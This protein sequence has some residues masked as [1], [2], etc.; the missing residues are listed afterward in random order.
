MDLFILRVKVRLIDRIWVWGCSEELLKNVI[1]YTGVQHV[2]HVHMDI[3][4][5]ANTPESP[6]PRRKP[7][8]FCAYFDIS[9]LAYP[10]GQFYGTNTIK[11]KHLKQDPRF[12][13]REKPFF[14]VSAGHCPSSETQ[15][16]SRPFLKTFAAVFPDLINCPWVSKHGHCHWIQIKGVPV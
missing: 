8:Q 14:Y 10:S 11:L 6:Q 5:K 3:F 7:S 13:A 4:L 1:H 15:G 16:L 12:P 2:Q 9:K